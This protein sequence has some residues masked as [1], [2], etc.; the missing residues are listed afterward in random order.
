MSLPPIHFVCANLK[1]WSDVEAGD[2]FSPDQ[3]PTR[4]VSGV[5]AW[6]VQTFL[7]LKLA[8]CS[9]TLGISPRPDAICV[10]HFDDL[11][12][13]QS[14]WKHYLVAVRADRSPIAT[15]QHIVVQNPELLNQ[16]TDEIMPPATFI[17]H[18]PQPGLL[19]RDEKRIPR[20]KRL[21]FMGRPNNIDSSL[22]TSQFEEKVRQ[23]GASF[24]L[25]NDNWHDYREVDAIVALRAGNARALSVKPASKLVNAWLA[26]CPALLGDES[27][28]SALRRSDL[29]YLPI[30]GPESI[31]EAVQRLNA[32]PQLYQAMIENGR[33]RAL[34][35][36]IA[37][38]TQMWMRFLYD[39]VAADFVAWQKPSLGRAWQ[40][41][42]R[43][44]AQL[45]LEHKLRRDFKA[46]AWGQ[47]S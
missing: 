33:A 20:V 24:Y 22:Q 5:E 44:Q 13:L 41:K 9:V 27:A 46:E 8:G 15:A 16:Q 26:G 3:L 7:R 39:I 45:Q 10:V 19:A 42:R 37:S 38:V 36:N 18:W 21:V 25:Q 31:I 12:N 1:D 47:T 4:F 6:I 30:D 14:P 40:R 2:A 35:H 29:D 28:F 34:E 43:Y 17:G 11:L 23:C 32:Q